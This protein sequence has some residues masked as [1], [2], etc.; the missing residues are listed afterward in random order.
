MQVAN[1]GHVESLRLPVLSAEEASHERPK[2][3]GNT[4]RQG[5]LRASAAERFGAHTITPTP[6]KPTASSHTAIDTRAHNVRLHLATQCCPALLF[7]N[8]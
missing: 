5:E 7:G 3:E 4:Q 1:N 6:S 8:H 2:R